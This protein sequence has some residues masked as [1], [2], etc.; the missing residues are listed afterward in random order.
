MS[1]YI[2]F[3]NGW[4]KN[5]LLAFLDNWNLFLKLKLGFFFRFMAE[6]VY[7]DQLFDQNVNFLK[8]T[9]INENLSLQA[10]I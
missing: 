4:K 8:I 10:L 1:N 7:K 5:E 9:A 3:N 6:R 2:F